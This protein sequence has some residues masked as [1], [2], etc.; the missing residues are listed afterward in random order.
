MSIMLIGGIVGG[1][2]FTLFVLMLFMLRR[3]VPTN[4]VH[5]VQSSKKTTPYGRG[6][7][8]GNTYY[9]W[10]A[11]IPYFGVTVTQFPESNFQVSLDNYDAYDTNR[12]PF[13]VDVTAFFRVDNAETAAQRISSFNELKLQLISV[14][15]GSVRR[16][17]ATNQLEDIM[18]ERSSLGQQF[19]AEV[20]DQIKE[21]GVVPVK[22]IEF[23]D[24]R[25]SPKAQVIA[26]IMAKE[27]S[28]IDKESRV[29]VAANQ[30]E[31]KLKEIDA[32]RTVEVQRQDAEQQVGLRTA[33]KDKA[34]GIAQQQANQEVLTQKKETTTREMDIAKVTAV[35]QAD[36]DKD[37]AVVA[38]EQ[39]KRQ[40]E[41]AA[42]ADKNV[43]V[44]T[45]EG[46]KT[47]MVTKAEGS[48]EAA[49]LNAQGIEAEG[50]AKGAAEQ[51]ILMAPVQ[52]QITLAQ[53]IGTN[54]GYQRYLIQ[55]RQV[56][57]SEHVGI[58][59][60][61]AMKNADLK[62]IANSGDVQ[63]GITKLTDVF[64]P[65]GGTS[66]GGMLEALSQTAA[67]KAVLDKF[68]KPA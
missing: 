34:V 42:E 67:G 41:I 64:T 55:I 29:A 57:A 7:E 5:I 47:A 4:M 11:W 68:T 13:V 14:L 12:L 19:T 16:I 2:V 10:P 26:N 24:L 39:Q 60:A 31:A 3:V 1:V 48:L 15:Q 32:Q 23:M 36:I 21:W 59:M 43:R 66:L 46:E 9:E 8:A 6:K 33:E 27:Q 25:D 52:T 28:R 37:V 18:Q 44:T 22:T 38:A 54:E 58:E 51:A 56:E 20:K 62:I 65:T 61:Q 17:L 30:Q 50:K 49:K 35:R 53:E 63:S 40:R 45:A